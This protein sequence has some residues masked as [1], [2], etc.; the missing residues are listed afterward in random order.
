M[1]ETQK[2]FVA[3]ALLNKPKNFS[4]IVDAVENELQI[5]AILKKKGRRS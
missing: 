3:N 2:V 1:G 4:K 5:K